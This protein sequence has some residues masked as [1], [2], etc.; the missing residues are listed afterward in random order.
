MPPDSNT[1]KDYLRDILA[2][3]KK[4]MKMAD[5]KWCN[6]PRYDEISVAN[7]YPK[8]A[9]DPAVSVYL[10]SKLPKG[11]MVDRAYFFNIL[12]TVYEERVTAMIEHSN[13]VRFQAE[14]G[15]IQEDTVT[16]TDEWWQRLNSMPYFS[17]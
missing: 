8:F 3:E 1:N 6:P 12:N 13:K 7:L 2:G 4:L 17:Q 10:P 11:K 14:P 15:G 9:N 5:I 16:V